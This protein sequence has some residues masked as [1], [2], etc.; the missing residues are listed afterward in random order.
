[1][2]A[3]TSVWSAV[4]SVQAGQ[5]TAFW[6]VENVPGAQAW[7]ARSEVAVAAV[8]TRVPAAQLVSEAQLRSC[9]ALGANAWYSLIAHWVH[10]VQE[11]ALRAELNVAAP[12]EAHWRSVVVVGS[13][14]CL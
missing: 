2:P 4:Q 5:D 6:V 3:V 7:Q 11:T 13:A 1:V 10:A 14:V 9:C 8:L 12:Q